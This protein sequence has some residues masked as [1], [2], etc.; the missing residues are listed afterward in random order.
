VAPEGGG[1]EVVSLLQEEEGRETMTVSK[2]G[3]ELFPQPGSLR[4][5]KGVLAPREKKE[6]SF[7]FEKKGLFLDH[8]GLKGGERKKRLSRPI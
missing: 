2:G 8:H 3:G 5:T 4:K 1:G 6:A 7:R